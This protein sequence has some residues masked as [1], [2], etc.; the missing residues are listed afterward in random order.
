M[1]IGNGHLIVDPWVWLKVTTHSLS[2]EGWQEFHLKFHHSI[3]KYIFF[4]NILNKVKLAINLLI[5]RT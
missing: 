3:Q 5:S 2:S 4:Q 1:F